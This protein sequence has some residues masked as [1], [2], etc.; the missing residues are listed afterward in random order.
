MSP[1]T[2]NILSEVAIAYGFMPMELLA[3]GRGTDLMFRARRQ[4]ARRLRDERGLTGA[5]IG[6]MLGRDPASIKRMLDEDYRQ[7]HIRRMMAKYWKK[8]AARG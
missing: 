7:R 8:K 5:H 6:R 4:V 2:R 1:E 3:P